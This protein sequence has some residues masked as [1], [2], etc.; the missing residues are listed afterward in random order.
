MSITL[1]PDLWR[2]A[3]T[4]NQIQHLTAP[5]AAGAVNTT[6]SISN[7]G[8]ID[9][10]NFSSELLRE[11]LLVISLIKSLDIHR[12]EVAAILISNIP[13]VTLQ[14]LIFD[15]YTESGATLLLYRP[16]VDVNTKI[17][18]GFTISL[19]VT[20]FNKQDTTGTP[21]APTDIHNWIGVH[22]LQGI[23]GRMLYLQGAEKQRIRRQAR[24]IVAMRSLALARDNAL[25]R[26]G[27]D[28]GVPRLSDIR[29]FRQPNPG[30]E[31][32]IFNK[33]NFG[34][35][36]FGAGFS[37]EII[38][39][40]RREPD[41]EYR[42][43]LAIYQPFLIPNHHNILELLNGANTTVE[44][45]Q[46]LISKLGFQKLFEI[47]EDDNDFGI[48]IHLVAAGDINQ[49][50]NFLN[51]IRNTQLIFPNQNLITNQ[52]HRDRPQRQAKRQQIEDLRNR[53]NQNFDFT[54]DPNAAIAPMLAT[55]IDRVGRCLQALGVNIR[56]QVFRAQ[57]ERIQ[58]NG[59]SSRYELGL[60]IE[61]ALL[62]LAQLT[63]IA[64]ELT[65][66]L[67]PRADPEIEGLLQSMTAQSPV[68]DPEG[69]WLLQPCGIKTT[70]RTPGDRL[71]L[72]HLPTFGMEIT[73]IAS[74]I[75]SS[76]TELTVRY[77][78][79][80]DPGGNFVLTTGLVTALAQWMA[81][82]NDPWTQ[83]TD[84][85]AITFWDRA[86]TV[87][88]GI[89]KIFE[90]VGLSAITNPNKVVE[91]LKRLP[92]DG[93]IPRELFETISL[94]DSI[95]QRI[96][97]GDDTITNSLKQL[98]EILRQ[99]GLSSV[100]PLITNT[101][102]LLVIGVTELPGVGVNLSER[103]STG[104]RWYVVPI[105][106][107]ITQRKQD[108]SPP[109][110]ISA[111]GSRTQ[112]TPGRSGLLA[113]VAVGYARREL[114][115]PYQFRVQLPNDAVLTF[116]QYE[117]LMNLLQHIHPLGVEVDTFAI[118]QNHV[119]LDGNGTA[120]PLP[121]NFSQTYRQFRRSRYRGEDLTN[122]T[123]T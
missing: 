91:Q 22:L 49:R 33:F 32:A 68:D 116:L 59:G 1:D 19:T 11:P 39:E 26:I 97:T 67:R 103:R 64:T 122:L 58:A 121:S 108:R 112:L 101:E 20:E 29:T 51:H 114:T 111:T 42:S 72:S 85:I 15:S 34:E 115:D 21:I 78:A 35:L 77:N 5:L 90:A 48:A 71:Y 98:V 4:L 117:F 119:D 89:A 16:E 10:T 6:L 69:R 53:L 25:D 110:R 109:D 61:V 113:I 66:P 79:P 73:G 52:I 12:L 38:S 41:D 14:T 100:L 74:T 62:T 86:R 17:A 46:G 76:A 102:V 63:Q 106:P 81:V 56:W 88:V 36:R 84:A 118:R 65:D 104:F 70:H 2:S 54:F 95:S 13:A 8:E 43:R 96:L 7:T 9:T 107:N 24:E 75:P 27:A 60:G 18:N 83:L 92:E 87:G 82:P 40:P 105:Y 55:A 80:G 50:T 57:D 47:V 99:N 23:M 37:G 94:P 120:A 45:N 30:E 28:L 3:S 93:G 44:P 31:P 123:N